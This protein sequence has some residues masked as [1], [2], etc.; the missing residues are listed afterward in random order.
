MENWMEVLGEGAWELRRPEEDSQA[1]R[2]S[3]L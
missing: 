1:F 2:E 3:D